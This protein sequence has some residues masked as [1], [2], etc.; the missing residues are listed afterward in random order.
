MRKGVGLSYY[1]LLSFFPDA[2]FLVDDY[3]LARARE[4]DYGLCYTHE[5]VFGQVANRIDVQGLF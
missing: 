5:L 4:R 3:S 2:L 1:T